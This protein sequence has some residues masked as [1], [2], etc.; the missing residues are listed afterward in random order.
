MKKHPVIS[1][2]IDKNTGE[3]YQVGSSYQTDDKDRADELAEKGFLEKEVKRSGKTN[4]KGKVSDE[5]LETSPPDHD[6]NA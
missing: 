3:Y 6:S 1:A 5:H 4:T 2:F